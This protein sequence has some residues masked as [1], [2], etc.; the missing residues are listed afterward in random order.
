MAVVAGVALLWLFLGEYSGWNALN[1][2]N[3]TFAGMALVSAGL[4]AGRRWHLV[5]PAL[6]AAAGLTLLVAEWN[7]ARVQW[8][9]PFWPWV[10]ASLG[11]CA[12][13]ATLRP[14]LFDQR[15][16]SRAAA[17]AMP[18]PLALFAIKVLHP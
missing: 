4:A 13:A 16:A 9:A 12:A 5:L 8:G 2:Y 15:R 10:L 18:M 1:A 7:A 11:L 3:V 6:A 17:A 14:R